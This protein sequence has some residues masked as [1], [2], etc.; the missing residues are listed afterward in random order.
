MVL[1]LQNNKL[2][3]ILVL[4]IFSGCSTISVPPHNLQATALKSQPVI[5]ISPN[6]NHD[7]TDYRT[8]SIIAPELLS[9]VNSNTSNETPGKTDLNNTVEK[10]HLLFMLRNALEGRG[11]LFINEPASADFIATLESLHKNKETY[12]TPKIVKHSKFSPNETFQAK[13]YSA[14]NNNSVWGEY[15]L[16]QATSPTYETKL[17]QTTPEGLVGGTYYPQI[18]ITLFDK[19]T[20][21]V[22][23]QGSAVGASHNPTPQIS[24]Q[25]VIRSLVSQI[26]ASKFRFDNFPLNT[27][28]IGMGFAIVTT[29]GKHFYPAVTGLFPTGSAKEAGIKKADYLIKINNVSSL[30]KSTAEIA[31][32]LSGKANTEIKLKVWRTGKSLNFTLRRMR[33]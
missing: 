29:D 3:F 33:R 6:K 2:F 8:F 18:D 14:L 22:V 16:A 25:L 28:K 30:N 32:M 24:S 23:W 4:L 27:G 26:K 12:V 5:Q 9:K 17:S 7:L 11:Y 31:K 15:Y 19:N 21:Q 1:F 13:I 20:M 10:M